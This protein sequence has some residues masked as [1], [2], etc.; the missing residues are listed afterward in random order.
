MNRWYHKPSP[1]L[2]TRNSKSV[3]HPFKVREHVGLTINPYQGCQ[4]RCGYCYAT[5]EWSPEF[6]DKIYAKSNAAEV[7]ETQ[8]KSGKYETHKPVMISSATDA[9]Q[10]AEIKFGITRRCIEVLQ[11]YKVPYYVF[12]KSA[13]IE[14]D[15]G[16]HQRY[17]GDCFVVWSITTTDERIR[18]L[19]EPGTPPAS[20]IF[21]V[22]KKFVD[23]GVCCAVNIDPILPLITDSPKHLD[24]IVSACYDTGVKYVSGAILRLRQDIW[25]RMKAILKL[26]NIENGPDVYK[27]EVYRFKEPLKSWFN[28]SAYES[29]QTEVIQSLE[30]KV[31]Q[32]EMR[33]DF[34]D[35][36]KSKHLSSNKN[37]SAHGEQ[38]LL[39]NYI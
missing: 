6:Y 17:N 28:V 33:F 23:A 24:E 4:H 9:Y 32:K 35:L 3:I 7:L 27:N 20:S 11:K 29:Y 38:T 5:Y 2:E 14:R 1:M 10:P 25:E 12:T 15:L 19:V 34:P 36:I 16:L 30:E 37:T 31:L 26:L 8:L 22:I 13:I 18:R 21:N 39:L